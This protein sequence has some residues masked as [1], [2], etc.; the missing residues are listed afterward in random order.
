MNVDDHPLF[1]VHFFVCC[2]QRENGDDCA[3]KGASQLRDDLKKW[4]R[5]QGLSKKIRINQAGCLGRCER[6]IAMVAYPQGQWCL[7]GMPE[8]LPQLK[9]MVLKLISEVQN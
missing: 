3:S 2:N 9:E 5:E 8:D 4:A 7:D 1:Q 6:G